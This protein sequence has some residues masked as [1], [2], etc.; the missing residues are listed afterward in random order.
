MPILVAAGTMMFMSGGNATLKLTA[1]P[2]MRGR[3]MALWTVCFHGS[4]PIGGPLSGAAMNAAG[5]R[6]GL[7]LAPA[8]RSVRSIHRSPA[9]ELGGSPD[10]ALGRPGGH[11]VSDPAPHPTADPP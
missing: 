1:G 9:A 8:T 5:A 11:Q 2:Q 10:A 4:S 3:I 6:A 7:G